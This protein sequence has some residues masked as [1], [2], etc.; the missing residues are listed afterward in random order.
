MNE[1]GQRQHRGMDM[2]LTEEGGGEEPLNLDPLA[3]QLLNGDD[4]HPVS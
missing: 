2:E 1:T 3:S 4:R